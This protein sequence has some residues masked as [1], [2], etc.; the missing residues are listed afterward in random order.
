MKRCRDV[1]SDRT[2][3]EGSK[4]IMAAPDAGGTVVDLSLKL[5]AMRA[6]GLGLSAG[7]AFASCENDGAR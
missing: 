5:T 2:F 4:F 1:C 7:T 6:N 3:S